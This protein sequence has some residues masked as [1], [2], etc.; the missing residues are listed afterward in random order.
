MHGLL[1][2]FITFDTGGG[3]VKS[4]ANG[5]EGGII[6]LRAQGGAGNGKA[7][8]LYRWRRIKTGGIECV[9]MFPI[10]ETLL[11]LVVLILS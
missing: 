2:K 7:E 9:I 8:N 6:R 5:K 11:L 10:L 1:C 3:E 4:H